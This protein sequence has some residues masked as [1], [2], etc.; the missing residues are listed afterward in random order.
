M[1]F[2]RSLDIISI[3]TEAVPAGRSTPRDQHRTQMR[4][5][6]A[7][8]IRSLILSGRLSP[9]S[10]VRLEPLANEFGMSL[11]PIRE[12]MMMLREQGFVDLFP[13]R[14][15]TVRDFALSD[16]NDLFL[17]QS[18]IGSEL[19]ARAAAAIDADSLAAVE[20]LQAR[21]ETVAAAD[22]GRAFEQ[23]NDDF[24]A[25][26]ND[27]ARSPRLVWLYNAAL[28][29]PR[30]FSTIPGWIEASLRDHR[31]IL[32]A[33]R[34]HDVEGSRSLM[35]DHVRHAGELLVQHLKQDGRWPREPL[36]E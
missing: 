6:A 35:S 10:F 4:D 21:L 32:A 34:A 5:E 19:A 8:R 25:R 17:I 15:F 11:T 30:Y 31:R 1:A 36:R 16:L 29:L 22:E 9:G 26:I 33:L 2:S 28:P 27:S 24:H 3:V 14:G 20:V 13:N 7:S 23:L 18:M 12:G